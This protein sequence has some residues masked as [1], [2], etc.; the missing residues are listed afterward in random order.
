MGDASQPQ[1]E[2]HDGLSFKAVEVY[3]KI[4]KWLKF[5]KSGKLPKAFKIIPRLKNWEQ[6]LYLTNPMDWSPNAMR[7]ATKIFAS[8]LNPK[9]AQRFYCLLVA[10]GARGH[11]EEP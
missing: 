2:V 5:Y 10:G 4:G 11:R 8:N 1:A 9:M 6:V 7:E 3:T